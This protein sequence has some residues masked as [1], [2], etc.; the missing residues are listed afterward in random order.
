MSRTYRNNPMRARSRWFRYLEPKGDS[1]PFDK[2]Y[3]CKDV[4]KF[5]TWRCR[6]EDYC[7]AGKLHKHLKKPTIHWEMKQVE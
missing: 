1:K 3:V 7:I 4:S 5:K 6:C 2:R